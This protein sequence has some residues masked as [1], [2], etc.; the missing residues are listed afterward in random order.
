MIPQVVLRFFTVFYGFLR[1]FTVS[2]VFYGFLRFFAFFFYGFPTVFLRFFTVF[3]RLFYGFSRFFYG[4][5]RLLFPTASYGLLWLS[6]GSRTGF[7]PLP[8]VPNV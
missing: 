5:L 2:T 7:V 1:V 6:Y 8:T 4:F 3:L